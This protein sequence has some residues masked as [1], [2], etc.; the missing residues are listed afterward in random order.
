MQQPQC[1]DADAARCLEEYGED[2]RDWACERCNKRRGGLHL[3]GYT[4]K[5]LDI[6]RLQKAGYPFEKNDLRA[7]EWLDLAKIKDLETKW[8]IAH[9]W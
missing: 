9:K 1:S 3:D 8:Q 5:L 4:M 7:E 6:H 2:G